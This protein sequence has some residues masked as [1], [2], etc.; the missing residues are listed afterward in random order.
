MSRRCER[1]TQSGPPEAAL[2][3][4]AGTHVTLEAPSTAPLDSRVIAADGIASVLAVSLPSSPPAGH[5]SGA[6]A[7]RALGSRQRRLRR[8]PPSDVA[9]AAV[10]TGARARSAGV[11]I[12]RFF[13]RASKAVA[14]VFSASLNRAPSVALHVEA[15]LC[16]CSSS[17]RVMCPSG[18]L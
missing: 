8:P 12:G 9:R 6:N 14:N 13:T 2:T 10:A 15:P 16:V 5:R 1:P 3:Q 7:C 11:S 17:T 18:R 4:F